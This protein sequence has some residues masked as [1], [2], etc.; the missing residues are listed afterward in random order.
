MTGAVSIDYEAPRFLLQPKGWLGAAFS[1][2][3]QAVSGCRYQA[4]ERRQVCGIDVIHDVITRLQSRGFSLHLSDRAI[5]KVQSLVAARNARADVALARAKRAG[6]YLYQRDGVMWLT[7]R[8]RGLLADEM[9]LG[10]TSQTLVAAGER[11]LVICPAKLKGNWR[12]EA[13]RWRPELRP[14]VLTGRGSFAW[15]AEGEI[16]I[17][18]YEI[19]GDQGKAV[20]PSGVSLI[21]DEAHALKNDKAARTLAVRA[22]A[23]AV[24]SA[25]GT[26]WL[27]TGTPLLNRPKELWN[28][29]SSVG[30]EV[31][32]FE[33]AKNFRRLFH[34]ELQT[35]YKAGGEE[36]SFWFYPGTADPA[37]AIYLGRVMLRRRRQ[38]VRTDMPSKT[39]Q[40]L[41]HT[42]S[43]AGRKRLD[44]FSSDEIELSPDGLR[45]PPFTEFSPACAAL[46]LEKY[47]TSEVILEAFEDADEP[48]VFFSHYREV[49]LAAGAR[50][51]WEAIVGGTP[52]A[53]VEQIIAQFQAGELRGLAGTI[54]ALGVGHTLHRAAFAVFNDLEWTPGLNDQA[55]DRIYR[56]GQERPVQITYVVA[57]HDIDRR[58]HTVLG[59]RRTLTDRAVE[60]RPT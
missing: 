32:A 16:V 49:A 56:I 7:G 27:L 45:L 57:D 35:I 60:G 6:L 59:Q 9:G 44:A 29:L 46:A 39:T 19:V 54:G 58:L 26:A 2:Y 25:D 31:E 10:K 52:S 3:L 13:S 34:A 23:G 40:I 22:V 48:V 17:T 1:S 43:D 41:T 5:V 12:N 33:S 42:L 14:R 15:P 50:E 21:V 36:V 55:A 53:K 51:G 37:A 47:Q 24:L 30:L 38:D 4:T 8:Q 11:V 20:A 28:V 18:N